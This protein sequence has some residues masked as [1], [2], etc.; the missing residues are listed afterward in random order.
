MEQT[1]NQIIYLS[2][3]PSM[4]RPV[5]LDNNLLVHSG[6][7]FT[8]SVRA[9]NLIRNLFWCLPGRRVEILFFLYAS[10]WFYS[11]FDHPRVLENCFSRG[12][13]DLYA[14]DFSFYF[15]YFSFFFA[16]WK[17]AILWYLFSFYESGDGRIIRVKR[18]SYACFVTHWSRLRQTTN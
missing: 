4:E 8:S 2:L 17:T 16:I 5:W 12:H 3:C 11:F 7:M 10:S 1:R 18:E 13:N 15:L 6:L 14:S 9:G